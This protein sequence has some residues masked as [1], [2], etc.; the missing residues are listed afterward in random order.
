L[1]AYQPQSLRAATI[2]ADFPCRRFFAI[3]GIYYHT[4]QL[5]SQ[6]MTQLFTSKANFSH[7]QLINWKHQHFLKVEKL[8]GPG[9]W[10]VQSR[11]DLLLCTN[12]L[13]Y[14]IL[15]AS[16][17]THSGV[18]NGYYKYINKSPALRLWGIFM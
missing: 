3:I 15:F 11:N 4:L 16:L 10:V 2:A 18:R 8:F 1:I 13:D 5:S 7:W 17:K 9:T 14:F 6:R 12:A